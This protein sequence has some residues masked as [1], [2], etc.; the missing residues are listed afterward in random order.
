MFGSELSLFHKYWANAVK[1]FYC[2]LYLAKISLGRFWYGLLPNLH[3]LSNWHSSV[4]KMYLVLIAQGWSHRLSNRTA[5]IFQRINRERKISWSEIYCY[6]CLEILPQ[7]ST[8]LLPFLWFLFCCFPRR[9]TFYSKSFS[10]ECCH[11]S[12]SGKTSKY[13]RSRCIEHL[14]TQ[15]QVRNIIGHQLWNWRM[16]W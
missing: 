12:Y 1:I 3:H 15:K 10:N 5:A 8:Q 11:L 14:S 9:R 4:Y 6:C 13:I 7:P 2:D 16:Q